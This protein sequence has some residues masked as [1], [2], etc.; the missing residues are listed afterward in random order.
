[1]KKFLQYLSEQKS[2]KRGGHGL[3]VFDID[4]TLFNTSAKIKVKRG[5]K[6]VASLSNA[7]YNTHELPPGHHYDYSEFRSADK[8]EKESK[9]IRRMLGKL[10]AIHN[11]IKK[12]KGSRVILNTARADFDDREKFLDT[13]RKHGIDIDNIHVHRAGNRPGEGS[14]AKKKADEI[15]P[16]LDTGKYSR[17]HVY[18]DS[19]E[20]LRHIHKLK[21][22]YPHIE[23][24][25]H[26]VSHDGSTTK[27][28][29][30]D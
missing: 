17:V 7:E 3:H 6:E 18:D 14:V 25:T 5:D 23:F 22:D 20:N 12:T 19:R 9:P 24:H 15:R 28:K 26:H 11:Q 29:E 30:G 4:D 16:H 27:F 2:Q 1:M 10:K 21:K 13:F 8:F